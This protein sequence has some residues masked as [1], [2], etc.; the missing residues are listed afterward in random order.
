MKPSHF[1]TPRTR[2][3]CNWD[4]SSDPIERMNKKIMSIRFHV[5]VLAVVAV[6]I[7]LDTFIWRAN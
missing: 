4:P 6:V 1:V 7:A 3:D 2:S 5:F